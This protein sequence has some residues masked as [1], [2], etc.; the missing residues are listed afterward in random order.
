MAAPSP[1]S[2]TSVT[3]T[4]ARIL[5]TQAEANRLRA[6]GDRRVIFSDR[7]LNIE[8]TDHQARLAAEFGRRRGWTRARTTFTIDALA[9]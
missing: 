2:D 4:I 9:R 7:P 6:S 8:D 3:A 5:E 1:V